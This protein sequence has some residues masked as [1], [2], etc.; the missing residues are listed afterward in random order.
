MGGGCGWVPTRVGVGW[1]GLQINPCLN[2]APPNPAPPAAVVAMSRARLGLY[3]FGRAGLFS[4]CYE[5]QPTFSQL[6]ARPQ[7]LALVPGEH[8]GHCD[9]EAGAA[10]PPSQLVSGVEHMAG[11]VQH[12]AQ[13]WESAATAWAQ[14]Q[15]EGGAHAAAAG[16]VQQ[17]VQDTAPPAEGQQ[18]GEE[19]GEEQEDAAED[20][21]G[22]QQ[23]GEEDDGSDG[24]ENEGDAAAPMQQD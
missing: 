14:T 24:S 1:Q 19:E 11:I 4:N 7:Q 16:A 5:L 2:P 18:A 17:A 12:M 6:L 8:Y 23:E 21:E 20:E 3:I 9:R 13:Q 10:P 15:G 22:E